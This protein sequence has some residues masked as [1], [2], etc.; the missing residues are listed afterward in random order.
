MVTVGPLTAG[1]GACTHTD[2]FGWGCFMTGDVA[3][4]TDSN[5]HIHRSTG[6]SFGDFT[7][8]FSNRDT[9]PEIGS[10]CICCTVFALWCSL[11]IL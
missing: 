10:L 11:T 7:E 9:I 6:S 4:I 8:T 1:H 2:G 5:R 3:G